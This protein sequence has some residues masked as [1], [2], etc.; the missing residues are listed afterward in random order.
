[1]IFVRIGRIRGIGGYGSEDT[2]IPQRGK[3]D[4]PAHQFSYPIPP[5]K[6]QHVDRSVISSYTRYS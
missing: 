5:G 3:I 2:A 4:D 6:G 1:M